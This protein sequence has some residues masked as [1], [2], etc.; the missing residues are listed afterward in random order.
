MTPS[1]VAARCL[2]E[3]SV[4]RNVALGHG[5]TA[6]HRSSSTCAPCSVP[7]QK[8]WLLHEQMR[9]FDDGRSGTRGR[10]SRMSTSGGKRC[11][12]S[13][14]SHDGDG[15]ALWRP[16]QRRV[17][18]RSEEKRRKQE[19]DPGHCLPIGWFGLQWQLPL[20]LI[21]VL[22]KHVCLSLWLCR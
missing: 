3:R 17:K 19:Y 16:W 9:E 5:G 20:H 22:K 8:S 21:C 14:D 2:P 4:P 1:I 10:S 18:K 12:A 6:Q 11:W 7:A 13:I 15:V